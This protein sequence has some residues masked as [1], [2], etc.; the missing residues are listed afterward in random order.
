VLADPAAAAA[1]TVLNAY[2]KMI[3]GQGGLFQER[4]LTAEAE[5]AHQLANRLS[6]ANPEGVFRYVALLADQKRF[7]E[8]RQIAQTAANLAPDNQQ[9]RD[10]LTSLNKEK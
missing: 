10:V 4:Q 7:D 1:P 9:F 3:L 2:A 6:P 5:Q 8:A